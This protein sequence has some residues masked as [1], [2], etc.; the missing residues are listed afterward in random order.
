M[1]L[2]IQGKPKHTLTTEIKAYAREKFSRLGKY[3]PA[4]ATV[5]VVLIDERGQKGGVDRAVN[6]NIVRPGE[7]DPIHLE[8]ISD[9]FRT[10]IDLLEKRTVRTL[11]ETKERKIALHRRVIGK[12]QEV[13]AATARQTAAIP[14]WIW[15]TVRR[16]LSRRGW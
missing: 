10:S 13:F 2:I 16:Q 5:E 6:I 14:G 1:Q 3:L 7:K 15:R 4:A 12:S 9:D 8:Q 11:R